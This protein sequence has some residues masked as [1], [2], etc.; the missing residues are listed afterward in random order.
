MADNPRDPPQQQ[1]QQ[2]PPTVPAYSS[3]WQRRVNGKQLPA[4]LGQLSG[5]VVT[6]GL[7]AMLPKEASGIQ[8]VMGH[9]L[10]KVAGDQS[11]GIAE[12]AAQSVLDGIDAFEYDVETMFQQMN[13][14]KFWFADISQD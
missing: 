7:N 5:I 1:P 3:D 9:I 12:S 8:K 11:K 6:I 13:D 4:Y 10:S 14:P 2:S